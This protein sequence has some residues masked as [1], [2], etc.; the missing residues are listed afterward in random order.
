MNLRRIL[1]K[2]CL[3][4]ELKASDKAGV[5][6]EL[7]DA[8]VAAGRLPE[9]ETGL[10]AV[11]ERERKM[12]TGLQSGIAIPHGK[13]DCVDNLVAVF[14]RKRAGIAFDSLDGQPA[15][16]FLLTLS[17]LTRTGPHIQFLA[18]ISRTLHDD[19]TRERILTSDN[20]DEI[21]SL[22]YGSQAT[23]A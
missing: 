17:P 16:I 5:L 7:V 22:L 19:A 3:V 4:L 10:R 1:T 20:A 14:G 12:S 2:D 15:R 13:T 8:L 11:L 23:T 18:E 21:L 9:R 6:A